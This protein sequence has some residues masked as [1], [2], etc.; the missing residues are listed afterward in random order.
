MNS[1]AAQVRVIVM[2]LHIYCIPVVD[3]AA[4]LI[5]QAV[6]KCNYFDCVSTSPCTS[7][8]TVEAAIYI[9]YAA[10]FHVAHML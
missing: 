9:H 8:T 4:F 1:A 2:R 10:V 3:R 5:T 6:D 7:S